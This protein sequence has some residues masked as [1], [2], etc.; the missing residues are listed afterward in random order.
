MSMIY[1]VERKISVRIRVLK[2]RCTTYMRTTDI[3]RGCL[4]AV[5]ASEAAKKGPYHI[6]NMHMDK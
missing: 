5:V 4:E 6:N 2:L 3:Y 1:S